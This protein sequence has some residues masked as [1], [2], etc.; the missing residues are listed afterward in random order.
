MVREGY[1]KD[2][3]AKR[4]KR[5][6]DRDG[7]ACHWC[8]TD[9]KARGTTATVDHV[10]SLAEGRRAGYEDAELHGDSNL[11]AACRSCN[12]SRSHRPGPPGRVKNQ[13]GPDSERD[14]RPRAPWMGNPPSRVDN[15]GNEQ[16]WHLLEEDQ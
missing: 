2:W 16:R 12:S 8:G 5:I 6:L 15:P 4:R 10:I 9:L 14:K 1:P 3:K 13:R 7:W 11:V